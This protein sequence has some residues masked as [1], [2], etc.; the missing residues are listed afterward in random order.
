MKTRYL[1][2]VMLV[3]IKPYVRKAV[4]ALDWDSSTS[5]IQ[6]FL[7]SPL[8]HMVVVGWRPLKDFNRTNMSNLEQL[9]GDERKC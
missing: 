6:H 5:N 8:V 7:S 1:N 4:Y 2:D 9:G 3:R